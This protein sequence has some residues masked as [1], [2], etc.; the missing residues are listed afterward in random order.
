MN[1][2]LLIVLIVVAIAAVALGVLFGLKL[3]ENK[4]LSDELT[5]TKTEYAA[6]KEKTA[7]DIKA[8]EDAK[9]ELEDI[10][11]TLSKKVKE[12][13]VKISDVESKARAAVA[14]EV[15]KLNESV[16]AAE[17]K[18]KEAEQALAAAKKEADAQKKLVAERDKTIAAKDKEIAGLNATVQEWQAKE[19]AAADLAE[20]YKNRLLENKIAL[21]PDKQFFG[22]VLVVNKEQEF[23]I[24]DLGT[25][26][27]LPVGTKLKVIRDN[28]L[29]GTVEVKKLL[30][31]HGKLS[32]AV[33]DSLID[34]ANPVRENDQVK[35]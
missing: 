13:E 33:V 8:L 5:S 3:K 4:R 30:P 31:E 23:L 14:A 29:I 32:V 27:L 6:Y 28:H 21:E 2:V 25:N 17:S 10:K 35:N 22:N 24:L 11:S 12:L 7:K 15:A 16:N 34:P 20:R 26:D 9:A 1:K 18:A 19:K